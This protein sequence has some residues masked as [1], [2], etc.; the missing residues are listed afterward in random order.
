MLLSRKTAFD[1]DSVKMVFVLDAPKQPHTKIK[2]ERIW[3]LKAKVDN[4]T[5]MGTPAAGS[6]A[7]F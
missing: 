4:N 3:A 5:F 1:G 7:I 2:P 6:H